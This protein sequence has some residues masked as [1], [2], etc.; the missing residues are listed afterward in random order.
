MKTNN[1]I[2]P[3]LEKDDDPESKKIADEMEKL[4]DE[5]EH[6]DPKSPNL[7]DVIIQEEKDKKKK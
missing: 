1:D 4:I 7:Y 2:L 3:I 5:D 6:F